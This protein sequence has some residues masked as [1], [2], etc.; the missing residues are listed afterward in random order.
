MIFITGELCK[1][2]AIDFSYLTFF[3]E[4]TQ[5]VLQKYELAPTTAPSFD[6]PLKNFK[7]DS[8]H[9]LEH[10]LVIIDQFQTTNVKERRLKKI[11]SFIL[12]MHLYNNKKFKKNKVKAYSEADYIVKF[13][14]YIFESFFV[15]TNFDTFWGDTLNEVC[16]KEGLQLKLDFRLGIFSLGSS[17][18]TATGE[19]AKK[20]TTTK[21]FGDKLKPI[22]AT[23]G[24]INSVVKDCNLSS[25][26]KIAKLKFPVIHV[27]GF[28]N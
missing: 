4:E 26:E 25:F 14:G 3:D 12:D 19:F 20:A 6:D 1:N 22:I 23:K 18:D 10:A 13:W 9:H 11:Y 8:K 16:K 15:E 24:V 21:Q 17:Y 5:N 28:D 7:F 27:M 2:T